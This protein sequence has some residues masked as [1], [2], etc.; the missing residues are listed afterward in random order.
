M[1]VL[2]F[3]CRG[4]RYEVNEIGQLRRTDMKMEFSDGWQ[5]LGG[6][7]HHWRNGIDRRFKDTQNATEYEGCLVWDR[8]HGTTRQWGGRYN[9]GLPRITSAWYEEVTQ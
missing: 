5:F 2:N 8:D 1:R 3:V 7:F 6:S 9:G 4:E